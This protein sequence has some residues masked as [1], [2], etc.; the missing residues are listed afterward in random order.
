[1]IEGL[2]TVEFR[3]NIGGMGTGTL[4]FEKGRV[5]GGDAGYYYIG[6]Y[7]LQ[8]DKISGEAKIQKYNPGHVSVFGPLESGD[9]KLSGIIQGIFLTAS[10]TLAQSPNAVITIKGIKRESF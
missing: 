5:A 3:T 6:N 4:I 7:T 9:L 1:M 10:G 8:G 2:W